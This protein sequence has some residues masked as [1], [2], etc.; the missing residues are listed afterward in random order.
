MKKGWGDR[1]E[2]MIKKTGLNKLAPED[3]GCAARRDYMNRVG[4][5]VESFFK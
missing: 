3:C 4:E 2:S 1:M 5:S